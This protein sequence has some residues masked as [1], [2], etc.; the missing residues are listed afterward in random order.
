[1]QN[2]Y[3]IFI[4]KRQGIGDVI[5]TTPILRALK[6]KYPNSKISL[7]IFPNAVDAVAGLP[8]IDE[9]IPYDKKKDS[10][11]SIIKRIW[12]YDVGLFLDLS[13]RPVLLSYLARIPVRIGIPHKRGLLLTNPVT[14]DWNMEA[15]YE[16]YNF[17]KLIE[18]GLGLTLEDDL[19]KIDVA[20]ACAADKKYVS[21]LLV[22][23]NIDSTKPLLVIAP[24]TAYQPKDWPLSYYQELINRIREK[25]K[26]DWDIILIGPKHRREQMF[27]IEGAANLVGLTTF[28]QMIELI[29]RSNAMI[30]SCSGNVHVGAAYNI[31]MVVFYG[32]GSPARWA[33]KHN[34]IVLTAN[35]QCAPCDANKVECHSNKCMKEINASLAFEAFMKLNVKK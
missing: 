20:S 2:F 3:K 11:L 32:P 24:F 1:M 28:G 19:T 12:R 34:T 23:H 17:A 25:Y 13:Y 6:E 8:Y 9:I 15:I 26:F 21:K 5:L 30:S 35:P 31:P 4:S 27:E 7:M 29:S 14:P 33:P 16:P 10:A 18:K 22:E